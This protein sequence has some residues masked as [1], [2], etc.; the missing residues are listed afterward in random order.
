MTAITKIKVTK[1]QK[2]QLE[3]VMFEANGNISTLINQLGTVGGAFDILYPSLRDLTSEDILRAVM[4]G[5]E[6]TRPPEYLLALEVDFLE[7]ELKSIDVQEHTG[8]LAVLEVQSRLEGLKQAVD[9]LGIQ[10]PE[11]DEENV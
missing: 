7:K 2:D 11:I 10:L 9:I 5:Y 3:K 4:N 8:Y 1:E 6:V